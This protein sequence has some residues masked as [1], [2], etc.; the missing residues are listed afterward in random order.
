MGAW[1]TLSFEL[2]PE[3]TLH[4]ALFMDVKNAPALIQFL[5]SGNVPVAFVNAVMIPSLDVVH[6]AAWKAIAD[7][8]EQS[9]M[10]RNVH[11]GEWAVR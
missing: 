8:K 2:D 5:S 9:L 3:Q 7:A 11:S 1:K 4:V 6:V 10:T